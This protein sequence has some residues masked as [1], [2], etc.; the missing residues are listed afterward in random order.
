MAYQN[1]GTPRFYVDELQWLRATGIGATVVSA[2]V[3]GDAQ[4]LIGLD[5]NEI[6]TWDLTA[7]SNWNQSV[8]RINLGI[9]LDKVFQATDQYFAILG[10]NLSGVGLK[11]DESAGGSAHWSNNREVVNYIYGDNPSLMYDGF[12]IGL[13]RNTDNPEVN[14]I[15]WGVYGGDGEYK[16]RTVSI[17]NVYDMP[18]SPDLNLKLTYEYDGIKTQQTKGGAT[19]S[20]A[21]YT[22]P[23][24]WGDM[25]AWQLG[26]VSNFRTGR[27]MWDLSF[28]YL[29]DSDIMP[30]LGVQNY[31][32]GVVTADILDSTDFFSQVWNKTIGG[33]LPFIFQPD[34]NNN[35]PDQFAICRFDMNSL[36][37]NQIG[38][39]LYNMQIRI[40]ESW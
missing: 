35:N 28:S 40:R 33:H 24:N 9:T 29:S 5:N 30:F 21:L 26:G 16:I 27:R 38:H 19:L 31:E 3:S 4:S 36:Q 15:R 6:T 1:V 11:I 23:P 34:N 18:H 14:A 8:N 39:N 32:E 20:N 10:H 17:G 37:L 25:G 12:S 7:D 13:L 2:P 22:K